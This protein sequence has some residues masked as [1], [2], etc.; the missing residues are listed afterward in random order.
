MKKKIISFITLVCSDLTVVFLSFWLAYLIRAEILP[1]LFA[2]FRISLGPLSVFMNYFFMALVWVAVFAYEKLYTKRHSFWEEVKILL[3]STT[4]SSFLIMIMIFITR[5]QIIFSRTVVVLA[6]LLS[7]ILFPLARFL[8]KL[9]LIKFNLWKKKLIILGVMRTSLLAIKSIQKNITMG[10]EIIGFLDD[11]PN[12]IGKK[13]G[14]VKVL[15]PISELENIA[16][17]SGSKDIMLS[18]PHLP[19]EELKKML[20]KCESISESLWLLPRIGDFITEGVEISTLGEVLALNIK[21]NL[22]KPWN[23]LIKNVFDQCLT[24]PFVIV[25]MPIFFIIALAIKLDSKGS[26]LFVQ[27]RLGKRKK[28]FNLYKFRSMFIDGDSYL[29]EYLDK[30][31]EAKEEWTKYKKLKKY[32]PRVTRVGRIIRKYSLDE[33][34]QLFNIIH[35]KMSLVGPRPYLEEELEGKTGFKN[36]LARVKPGIT[37]LWQISGR[38]ELPF[39]ERLDLDEYYIRNWSLWLDIIILLKSIKI[40]FSRKGAY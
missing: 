14:G 7:L 10:Y 31:P 37:G 32:D 5:K 3:K 18:I 19:R 9:L 22:T 17:T 12:K 30:N 13:F 27:K 35:G 15:G 34:P 2:K 38:S 1:L 36:T 33:L 23:V 16:K 21:R 26:L 20:L 4:I 39:E 11:D 29:T 40:W 25:L 28:Q 24:V 6:W 8:T